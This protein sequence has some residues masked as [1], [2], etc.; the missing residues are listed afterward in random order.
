MGGLIA[1]PL[2]CLYI[3]RCT[4]SGGAYV[5]ITIA[6]FEKRKRRHLSNAAAGV[7]YGLYRAIRKYG[8]DA[9]VWSII[10]DGHTWDELCAMERE[11]IAALKAAGIKLYNMTTGGDGTKGW[12][13]TQ[14]ISER[15]SKSAKKR[16]ENPD[17]IE[18]NRQK[19]LGVRNTPEQKAKIS[20]SLKGRKKSPEHA[21]NIS[22]GLKG[23]KFSADRVAR[24]SARM[25][26]IPRTEEEKAKISAK[27]KGVPKSAETRQRMRDAQLR[28]SGVL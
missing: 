22:N 24:M 10:S 6:G 1:E 5:G 8:A 14:E 16:F 2:G 11:E 28:R 4:I 21:R 17:Q 23:Q 9:F 26:G 12:S 7:R 27:L 20:R 18:W 19:S 3:A 13:L 15:M 25:M